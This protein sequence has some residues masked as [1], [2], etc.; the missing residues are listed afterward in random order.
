MAKG[1]LQLT[2]WRVLVH[3]PSHRVHAGL[4]PRARRA[5][6]GGDRHAQ[7]ANIHA[8]QSASQSLAAT[9]CWRLHD[10]HPSCGQRRQI[11]HK[12]PSRGSQWRRCRWRYRRR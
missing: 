10:R 1:A 2:P 3:A 7:E 4:P 6:G 12:L 8:F 5:A 11:P 9:C